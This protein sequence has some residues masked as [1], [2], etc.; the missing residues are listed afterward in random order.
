MAQLM[1]DASADYIWKDD[2][3]FGS[4]PLSFEQVFA[5]AKDADFWINLSSVTSKK[6]LLEFES[7]YAEFK[8]YKLGNLY[9]NNK[10]TNDKGYSSYWETGMIFPNR[11]LSDLIQI[12]HPELRE[13]LKTDFY[14]YRRLK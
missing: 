1:A 6:E 14:Y 2:E 7:R 3:K 11:I 4:V 12:F 9:N 10:N 5:R 13:E 8:A